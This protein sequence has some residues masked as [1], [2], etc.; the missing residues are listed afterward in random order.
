MQGER[1]NSPAQCRY[2]D[3][4]KLGRS[5]PSPELLGPTERG[6]VRYQHKLRYDNYCLR[7]HVCG[8]SKIAPKSDSE[9]EWCVCGHL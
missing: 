8:D 5:P 4:G 2:A 9:S 7:L 6:I 3:S 1:M